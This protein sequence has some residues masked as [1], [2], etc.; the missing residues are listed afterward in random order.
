MLRP[1]LFW[2]FWF[3]C[4]LIRYWEICPSASD[5]RKAEWLLNCSNLLCL[6][7]CN[8][9][10]CYF[11]ECLVKICHLF[12][13]YDHEEQKSDNIFIPISQFEICVRSPRQNQYSLYLLRFIIFTL[14]TFSFV[15]LHH[16]VFCKAVVSRHVAPVLVRA[17]VTSA[18]RVVSYVTSLRT[19]I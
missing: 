6:F 15:N 5:I 14:Q 1:K 19:V 13:F 4:L 3:L 12:A 2:K 7:C 10:Y 11:V 16:L 17:A 9:T 18:Q 8:K